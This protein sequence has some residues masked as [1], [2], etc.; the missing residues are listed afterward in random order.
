MKLSL[1]RIASLRAGAVFGSL[2]CAALAPA[3]PEGFS[4]PG[5][6]GGLSGASG[7]RPPVSLRID[8]GATGGSDAANRGAT[9]S[10]S[11]ASHLTATVSGMVPLGE[12][13]ILPLSLTSQNISL[14][15]IAGVPVPDSSHTLSFGTGLG[16][17]LGE[18]WM[19]MGRIGATL[20]RLDGAR[21]A[22]VGVS[23]GFNAVWR[24]SP[25]LTW[26]FGVM[27]NPD[28]DLPVL[29][30]VGANWAINDR[31]TLALLFPEP[32]LT[33]RPGKDWSF[34]VGAN[35]NGAVF[36]TA[37]DFGTKLGQPRYNHALGSY[38]DIRAGAGFGYRFTSTMSLEADV[39]TSV[40]RQIEYERVGEKVKFEAAPYF[41]VGLKFG[42]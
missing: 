17:R 1:K 35:L 9:H 29:P 40:N 33:Y 28:S 34:H 36:R 24:H 19:L 41:R 38:R 6:P 37:A 42:F 39:G 32:R 26:L 4:A 31:F 30:F 20:Y 14:D 15:E 25:R 12:G 18:E 21:L 23:G 11:G 5:G 13:W 8:Y 3:Q 22:D 16:H 2:F 10:G 27:F 7:G